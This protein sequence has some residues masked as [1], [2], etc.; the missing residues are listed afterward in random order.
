MGSTEKVKAFLEESEAHRHYES[1][2]EYALTYLI[3][4]AER[5]GRSQFAEDLRRTKQEYREDFEKAVA[6]TEQVFCDIFSDEELDDL[7]V[8]HS[9]PAIKKLRELNSQIMGE[10]LKKYSQISGVA[11]PEDL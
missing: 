10:I 9:N 3:A 4:K 11:L 5:E 7:V 2:V 6:L 8:L 1:I